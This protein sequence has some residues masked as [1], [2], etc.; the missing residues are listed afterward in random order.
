MYICLECGFKFEYPVTIREKH[1]FCMPPYET[2]TVC[3]RCKTTNYE[4]EELKFCHCCGVKLK[5]N[6]TDYCSSLC[7]KRAKMLRQKE[8]NKKNLLFDNPIY[9]FVREVEKYNQNH[10]KKLSYGQFAALIKLQK[11]RKRK[12]ANK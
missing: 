1:G 10:Q 2:F 8:A 5:E 3:P 9:E 7:K 6:Q 11:G 4:K 12:N